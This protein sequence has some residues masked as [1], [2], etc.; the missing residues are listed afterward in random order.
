VPLHGGTAPRCTACA[1]QERC[2]PAEMSPGDMARF[3]PEVRRCRHIRAGEHLFRLG[4]PLLNLYAVRTGAFKTF[5]VDA[6]GRE[7]VLNFNFPG[8]V[9]GLDAIWPASHVSDAV[10]LVDSTVC[11]LP[12]RAL[13]GLAAD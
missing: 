9:L 11:C 5:A 8:E 12:F 10:A 3:S 1:L 13:T 2:L 7:Q 6:G 4:D